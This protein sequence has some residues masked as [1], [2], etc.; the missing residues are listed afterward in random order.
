VIE[1]LAV[2]KEDV[3]N[4]DEC[5]FRIG[6]GGEQDV[7]TL[8]T[9]KAAESP[10][11]TNRDFITMVEAISAGGGTIP[12]LAIMKA[13]RIL[14]SH[15]SEEVDLDP[16]M[17]LGVSASGYSN[18]ELALQ[19]LVHFEKWTA[20][21]QVGRWRILIFDGH[22]SHMTFE[23]ISYCFEKL[24]WPYALPP[25]T[26][27]DLQPLDVVVSQPYKHWHKKRVDQH[28][29]LGGSDFNKVE[30]LHTIKSMRKDAF[31]TSTIIS[32]FRLSGIWPINA[33]I[34]L[35]KLRTIDRPVTPEMEEE[36]DD[37][38]DTPQTPVTT[39]EIIHFTRKHLQGIDPFTGIFCLLEYRVTKLAKGAVAVA[40]ARETQAQELQKMTAA[41]QHRN[42]R[43]IQDKHVVQSGGTVTVK[44]A[45]LTVAKRA[46]NDKK[47]GIVH[48]SAR[49]RTAL[50]AQEEAR[51][52]NSTP[53]P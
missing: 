47:K 35:S 31:K 33:Q 4:I 50:Q 46:V 25:H 5:G 7:I 26:S 44:D 19:Y 53:S 17:L 20:K 36:E 48:M 12:P 15:M 14:H 8:E 38:P 6:I 22:G 13:A 45:R 51:P 2:C 42:K 28:V 16:A 32:A 49:E 3:W 40:A 10:S 9:Y 11:E 30:F 29:R 27:Q 34:V 1:D 18:D 37:I 23:F 41:S 21:Q 24:I 43:Q 52:S 39:E